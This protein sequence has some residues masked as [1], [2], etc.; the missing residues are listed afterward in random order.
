MNLNDLLRGKNVD[1]EEVLV[2]RH[3]P[4]EPQL[5]KV[6]PWLASERHDLFNAYQAFQGDKLERA[7]IAAKYLASFIA[8]GAG[9][10]LFVGLY[11]IGATKTIM[12]EDFWK[13]AANS[14]LKTLGLDPA[15]ATHRETREMF[16]L[17][18]EDF[19]KHWK[20][21]L[22][23]DWPPPERSWWRRAHRNDMT[24]AA[25]LSESA[26]EQVATKTWDEIILTWDELR[27]MPSR[28]KAALHEWRGIYFI[29]DE[30]DGKGYVGSAYGSA[31]IQGRWQSYADLGHGGNRL[32]RK[33]N[34]K[35]FRFSILQRVSPDLEPADIIR[36]EGTWKERLHTRDPFG[37]NDN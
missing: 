27:V 9:K 31:N 13:V 17:Q 18:V 4:V 6:L 23:V 3:R 7:M 32:L 5:N 22:V 29:F 1:P 33:R 20:G 14:E 10:A 30:S 34:P 36:L 19:Y 21:K 24:V 12:S 8:H 25:I 28:L 16:D 35:N 15:A 11:S 37:L 2:L 26:L